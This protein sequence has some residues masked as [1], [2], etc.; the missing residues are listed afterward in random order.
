MTTGRAIEGDLAA[1]ADA[2]T[3]AMD[4]VHTA[5]RDADVVKLRRDAVLDQMGTRYRRR[6]AGLPRLG[7]EARTVVA[8]MAA[9]RASRQG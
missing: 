3:A 5:V 9:L 6:S 4:A 8:D 1:I 7:E 2:V